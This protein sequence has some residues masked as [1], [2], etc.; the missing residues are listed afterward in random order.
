M[1]YVIGVVNWCNM[2]LESLIV[3]YVIGVVNWC[4]MLLESLI[5]AICYWSR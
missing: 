5:G 4:N 2:L 3:Q 1:Q